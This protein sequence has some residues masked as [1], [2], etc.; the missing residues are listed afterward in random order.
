MPRIFSITTPSDKVQLDA[1]GQGD[2]TFVV[3]N[4]TH[5]PLR[6]QLKLRAQDSA[7]ADWLRFESSGPPPAPASGTAPNSASGHTPEIEREFADS[8]THHVVVKVSVP[9]NT[10][11]PA[12]QPYT[13]RLDAIST[14][15]PDEDYTEGPSVAIALPVAQKPRSFPWWILV[16]LAVI[17]AVGGVVGYL[18]LG[19]KS[20]RIDMPNLVGFPVEDAIALLTEPEGSD[21]TGE[22]FDRDAINVEYQTIIICDDPEEDIFLPNQVFQQTPNAGES[23]EINDTVTLI[24]VAEESDVAVPDVQGLSLSEAQTRL[25]NCNLQSSTETEFAPEETPGQVFRQDPVA[26]ST[27]ALNSTVALT[28]PSETIEMANVR[29]FNQTTATEILEDLGFVIAEVNIVASEEDVGNV[30]DQ[31]PPPDPDTTYPPGTEV[32]LIVAGESVRVPDVS[33]LPIR[34]AVNRINNANLRVSIDSSLDPDDQVHHTSPPANT[35]LLT[36]ESSVTLCGPSPI[37][38]FRFA[39]PLTEYYRMHPQIFQNLQILEQQ[40]RLPQQMQRQPLLLP[41]E[42]LQLNTGEESN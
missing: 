28:I 29:G 4:N 40:E 24:A 38:P 35:R 13:F 2:V 14:R 36:G 22:G 33:S 5:Y 30:I 10:P 31:D 21:T 15:N 25:V 11:Q 41:Q 19:S 7:Q 23:I 12:H 20:N 18:I 39:L 17:A 37:C 6:C 42:R 1:K 3:T 9:P 16:V 8:E 26:E 32:T 27:V 34:E